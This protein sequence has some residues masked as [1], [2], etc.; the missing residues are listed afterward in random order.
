[1]TIQTRITAETLRALPEKE[2]LRILQT[3]GPIKCQSLK[4]NWNF[5]ARDDQLL[6]KNVGTKWLTL[7]LCGGRGSGKT[8][9]GAEW[10]RELIQHRGYG[11]IAIVAPTAADARDVMIEGESGIMATSP[12]WFRPKYEPSKRRLTWPNGAIAG[13]FSAEEPDAFRGPQHDLIWSDE[14][15]RYP[16]PQD[17]L[18]MM[19]FGLR[20]G[21]APIKIITTTPA[22]VAALRKL[23]EDKTTYLVRASTYENR[24]NLASSFIKDIHDRY[25]GTRLG[26]QE[27]DGEML[28]DIE[29]ALWKEEWFRHIKPGDSTPDLQRVVIGVDPAGGADETGITV[30]GADE[31]RKGYVLADLSKNTSPS[32]WAEIVIRAYDKYEADAVVV[33][34]NFGGD[35]CKSTIK[36]QARAMYEAGTRETEFI[37]I[38]EVHASRGKVVRAEPISTLY[39]QGH[40]W[41]LN[42]FR[43]LEDEMTAFSTDWDRS[44]DG[45]PNRLDSCVW[46][47]TDLMLKNGKIG[48]ASSLGA[49]TPVN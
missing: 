30:A 25:G 48:V 16:H 24:S 33:E 10:T 11:R 19:N 8:R 41:H 22:R 37:N 13:V 44:R 36:Q 49:K 26:R 9:T 7:A 3:L 39:E 31:N 12:P 45:S 1:M 6:P 14:I 17:V 47:L 2:R 28:D 18:D 15:V 29:N 20:L 40:V 32:G 21:K 34:K 4:W 46:A 38:R 43:K 27:L 42:R 35:M 23:L 5:W